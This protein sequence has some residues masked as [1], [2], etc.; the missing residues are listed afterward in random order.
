MS[1]VN[2]AV[3]SIEIPKVQDTFLTA[4]KRESLDMKKVYQGKNYRLYKSEMS[5]RFPKKK[6]NLIDKRRIKSFKRKHGRQP[7]YPQ[8]NC[9]PIRD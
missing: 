6:T 7:R 4:R 5:L 8:G 3:T 9:C 1:W 2:M